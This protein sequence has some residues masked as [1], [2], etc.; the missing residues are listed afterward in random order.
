[1]VTISIPLL[2]RSEEEILGKKVEF[3]F[4]TVDGKQHKINL[5]KDQL[6]LT[7]CQVPIVYTFSEQEEIAITFINGKIEKIEGNSI[8]K[9]LS[10]L[11]FK[12]G[13]DVKL[14]EVKLSK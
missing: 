9:K 3:E 4:F 8:D 1:M 13:N 6:A 12:R 7:F 5:E 11:V 2:S 14:I 10:S